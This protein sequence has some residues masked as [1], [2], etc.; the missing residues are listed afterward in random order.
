MKNF[1]PMFWIAISIGVIFVLWGVL[2]P[3]ILIDVMTNTQGV[4][5]D[6]F[7]W[8]YQFSA[9][10]FFI[11]AIFFALSKYGKIRLG[12]DTDRP[13]YSTLT[14][15]AML[16]SA[17]MGIGLLFYGV[18][19]PVS[20]YATPPFGK[21]GTIESAKV[22]L[23]YTYLHWGFHAWAIYAVVAL[24]LAYYKFRKGMP[25]LMSATLY[26]V[27]GERAKGPIGYIVDIIAVFATIFGVAIS[28]GIGAQQINSGL[29]YLMDVPINFSIQLII[30]GIATVLYITSAPFHWE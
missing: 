15:F 22:G 3:Q 13:E 26:P 28:L 10:F 2:F 14:W 6:K 25:G 18:S 23:R 27:I 24:A 29:H 19:E 17:G 4:L 21:G 5:L 16:F 8:F 11:I 9:T 12:E 1:T 20:H 7:G 30:M